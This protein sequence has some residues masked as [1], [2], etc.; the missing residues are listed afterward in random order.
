MSKL[1]LGRFLDPGTLLSG[2]ASW[3]I[4]NVESMKSMAY[5]AVGGEPL[6]AVL[7][8]DKVSCWLIP[9]SH[10]QFRIQ[11]QPI[12]SNENILREHIVQT[13]FGRKKMVAMLTVG[14]E[15]LNSAWKPAG[16]VEIDPGVPA[17]P[18]APT[19]NTKLW[20]AISL[21]A[22]TAPD[23]I[24]VIADTEEH[25]TGILEEFYNQG[26]NEADFLIHEVPADVVRMTSPASLPVPPPIPVPVADARLPGVY[27]ESA[28]PCEAPDKPAT[29]T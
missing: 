25:V 18:V 17:V 7:D 22:N 4:R 24:Y 10:L 16:D 12:A 2:S 29:E 11:C 19:K 28:G 3:P 1:L 20:L 27:S 5:A 14:G 8:E 23:R 13:S 9:V 15:T 21:L 6:L 26:V